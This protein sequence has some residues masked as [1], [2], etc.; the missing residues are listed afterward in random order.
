[1]LH[2]QLR[3]IYLEVHIAKE[4]NIFGIA[5][6]PSSSLRSGQQT[7]DKMDDVQFTLGNH[8]GIAATHEQE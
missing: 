1:M 6:I 7:H 8:D 4:C 3:A 2:T 5:V